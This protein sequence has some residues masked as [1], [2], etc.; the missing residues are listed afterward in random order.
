MCNQSACKLM[1]I[2]QEEAFTENI[3]EIGELAPYLCHAN[4]Q[5]A[6]AY[7]G[8]YYLIVKR[9]LDGVSGKNILI[10]K[11]YTQRHFYERLSRQEAKMAAVGELSAGLAHEIRN[12]L[13]LIKS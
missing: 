7:G 6:F 9:E 1:R 10:I 8:K 13:G 3:D 4:Q 11:D 2:K 12:P 5:E